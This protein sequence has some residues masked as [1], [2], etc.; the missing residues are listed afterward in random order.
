MGKAIRKLRLFAENLQLSPDSINQLNTGDCWFAASALATASIHPEYFQTI[1]R[2]EKKTRM[3]GKPVQRSSERVFYVNISPGDNKLVADYQEDEVEVVLT[4][5]NLF[6][7]QCFYGYGTQTRF[8]RPVS[9]L[10]WLVIEKALVQ[11]FD[12]NGGKN[13][14]LLRSG[15]LNEGFPYMSRYPCKALWDKEDPR[16]STFPTLVQLEQYLTNDRNPIVTMDDH[17]AYAIVGVSREEN[18]I[19]VRCPNNKSQD[20]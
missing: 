10:A 19:L 15:R 1:V 18:C 12:N 17:H 4:E 20:Q 5:N 16:K 9:E 2:E 13:Y 3:D 6:P 8:R 11:K 14:E 7:P